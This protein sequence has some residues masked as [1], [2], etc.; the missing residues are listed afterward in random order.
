M[1][2]AQT[3]YDARSLETLA[4]LQR[5]SRWIRDGFGAALRGRVLEV[6]AGTG[7]FAE[8]WVPECA[9]AVLLEPAAS[10]RALLESRFAG[11]ARVRVVDVPLAD[12]TDL[13]TFDAVVLVNVLEHL[14]DDAA[15]LAR[16]RAHLAPGGAVL[17]FVPA[18]PALYGSLDALVGH[19]RR[20]TRQTLGAAVRAAGLEV[21]RMRWFDVL[22]VVPWWIVGRVLRKPSFD[23]PLAPLYDRA[24]VPWASVLERV[25]PPLLGKNLLCVARAAAAPGARVHA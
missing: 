4:S 3:D 18:L 23:G 8:T 15:E 13:G 22:G 19:R 16:V 6:G 21:V 9:S 12:A 24:V 1:E 7:N 10:P 11:D 20:Y 5:Y 14:D 17:L 2:P 25:L